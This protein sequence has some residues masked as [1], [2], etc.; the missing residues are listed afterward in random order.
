[1][2]RLR[3]KLTYANVISTLCLF[4]L[5]GGG[6][7]YA[8]NQLPKNSVGAKQLKKGAVTPAK[9]TT[10]TKKALIGPA[11][12]Q[13]LPGAPGAPGATNVVVRVGQLE[14]EVA[15]ASCQGNEVAVG[16]G[17][18]MV[19][20]G[21]FLWGSEPVTAGSKASQE[22]ELKD[23]EKPIGWQVGGEATGGEDS[24]PIR[25]YVLCASP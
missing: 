22:D 3:S 25:A 20:P 5:L 18:F 2:K 16:G 1:M 8:A 9:L 13:G 7:A 17:G 14:E 23:G 4:L 11:G 24:V 10:A 21:T 15:T 12:P 6:A 19:K